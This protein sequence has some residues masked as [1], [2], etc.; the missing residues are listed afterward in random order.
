VVAGVPGTGAGGSHTLSSTI[1]PALVANWSQF[2]DV[3]VPPALCRRRLRAR[4]LAFLSGGLIDRLAR[5]RPIGTRAFFGACGVFFFRFLRLTIVV[6]AAYWLIASPF[7]RLLFGV[8]VVPF[9][10]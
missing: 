6:G 5:A 3:G 4:R 2:V 1:G 8:P 10:V 9:S 7:H